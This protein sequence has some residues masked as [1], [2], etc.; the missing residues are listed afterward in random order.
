M[1]MDDFYESCKGGVTSAFKYNV[2]LFKGLR[3]SG[4]NIRTSLKGTIAAQIE[5]LRNGVKPW[6]KVRVGNVQRTTHH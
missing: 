5:Q 2:E 4:M 1:H 3:E 6:D